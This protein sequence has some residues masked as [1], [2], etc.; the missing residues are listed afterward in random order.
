[1]AARAQLGSIT[2]ARAFPYSFAR[3]RCLISLKTPL[4]PRHS[5]LI[6]LPLGALDF[7]DFSGRSWRSP[8]LAVLS[9]RVVGLP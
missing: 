7:V 6:G 8:P 3:Y 9:W 5:T 1:M 2:Q 4:G